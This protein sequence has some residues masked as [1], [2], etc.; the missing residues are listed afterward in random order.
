[1]KKTIFAILVLL[2]SVAS[3]SSKTATRGD[4]NTNSKQKNGMT[5]EKRTEIEVKTSLGDITIALYNETPKHRDNIIKLVK[6]GYYNETLFHRVIKEFMIQ[7]GDGDS[8]GAPQGKML[9]SGGPAYNVEAEIVYPKFFHKRGAIAAARQGDQVNPEKKSSGSQFYIVTGKVYST[10]EL[11]QMNNQI[12]MMRKQSVFQNL[13][14]AHREEIMSMQAKND[15]TGLNA[16]Q[17]ELISQTEAQIAKEPA[18]MTKEQ[19][20]AYSTVG[21]T[22]HLDGQYTVFGEVIDGMDVVEKIEKVETGRGDRPKTD[23]KIL[24]VKILK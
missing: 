5:T 21:G 24:D 22:P 23:V 6:E 3:C 20:E 16:L 14:N 19:R 17:K 2:C 4:R 10:E 15:T 7:A 13:A 9:G 18:G 1:M 8:K 11:D 12:V